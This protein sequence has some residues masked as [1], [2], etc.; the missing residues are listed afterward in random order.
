MKIFHKGKLVSSYGKGKKMKCLTK[1]DEE[2]IYFILGK[3]K[4]G[5]GRLRSANK[6]FILDESKLDI[7]RI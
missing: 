5:V 3:S 2:K 6:S 1:K 4:V 7:D